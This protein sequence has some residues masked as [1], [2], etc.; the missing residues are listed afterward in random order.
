M[1]QLK[2]Y[3]KM[4]KEMNTEQTITLVGLTACTPEGLELKTLVF[5]LTVILLYETA[6]LRC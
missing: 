6:T 1:I 5:P 3:L 4:Q 2:S